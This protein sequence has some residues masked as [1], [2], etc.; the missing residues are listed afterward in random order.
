MNSFRLVLREQFLE[1][2]GRLDHR[3]HSFI[4]LGRESRLIMV[5]SQARRRFCH[6][7][8]VGARRWLLFDLLLHQ[9]GSEDS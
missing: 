4:V 8:F 9:Q 7:A 2:L 1:I 3:R 5:F 6:L